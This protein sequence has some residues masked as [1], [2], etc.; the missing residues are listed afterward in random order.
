MKPSKAEDGFTSEAL[1]F[2]SSPKEPVQ[3]HLHPG[4]NGQIM[5][6]EMEK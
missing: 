1:S 4:V 2:S 6:D 5:F 3:L